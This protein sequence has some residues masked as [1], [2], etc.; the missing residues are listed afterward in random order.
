MTCAGCRRTGWGPGRLV[1][2]RYDHAPAVLVLRPRRGDT[3]VVDLYRCG[4]TEPLRSTTL[5]VR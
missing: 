4:S 2:V 5:P 1:G 3:L